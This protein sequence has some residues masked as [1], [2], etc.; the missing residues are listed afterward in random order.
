M[1][2]APSFVVKKELTEAFSVSTKENQL[3]YHTRH[4]V[5]GCI[6]VYHSFLHLLPRLTLL[7]AEPWENLKKWRAGNK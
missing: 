5:G 3:V 7:E 2:I 6:E 4:P 1:T